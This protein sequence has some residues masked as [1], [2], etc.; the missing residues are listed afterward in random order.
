MRYRTLALLVFGILLALF[1]SMNWAAMSA[2]TTLN[3]GFTTIQGPLGLVM[4]VLLG[5]GVVLML[6]YAMAIQ[7]SALL[8]T[9]NHAKEARALREVAE[10][11]E[12][13]RYTELREMVSKIETDSQQRASELKTWFEQRI[14]ALQQDVI[15]R[16]DH[17]GNTLA[18]YMGELEDRI[19]PTADG[20]TDVQLKSLP[21]T[22]AGEA[23]KAPKGKLNWLKPSTWGSVGAPQAGVVQPNDDSQQPPVV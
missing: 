5:I 8:E 14:A 20:V 23:A 22:Q 19:E 15:A 11:N 17:N 9:R 21:N 4:L 3:L 2:N 1:V 16:V 18:A 13:S 12:T 6:L 10:N 7:T